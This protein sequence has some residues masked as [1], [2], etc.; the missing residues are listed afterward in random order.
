MNNPFASDRNI[1]NNINRPSRPT[2]QNRQP[3]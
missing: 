3:N 1:F 2:Q